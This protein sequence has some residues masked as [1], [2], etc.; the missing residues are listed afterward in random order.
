MRATELVVLD[1]RGFTY[2]REHLAGVNIFC[3][4]LLELV[5]KSRGETFALAPEGMT[6]ER[7]HEFE[8]GGLLAENLDVSRRFSL[9]D[10]EGSFMEVASLLTERVARLRSLLR[11]GPSVCI[12]DDF[13]P[14]WGDDLLRQTPT[15]FGVD[16]E[17]YHLLT[18]AENEATFENVIGSSD[19]IW[20][21]VAAVCRR[22]PM[23]RDDRTST[24]LELQE[25]AR[26][27]LEIT[28][29]AYDGEGFVGWRYV[30]QTR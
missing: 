4:A 11:E 29:S 21:G 20:H 13:N 18:L 25:C 19:T 14:K 24:S 26:T 9:P 7:L 2:V 16:G 10:M 12:A 22:R 30:G 5:E 23:I 8:V 6:F 28:C 17:V 15:A 1:E 27:A 3:A